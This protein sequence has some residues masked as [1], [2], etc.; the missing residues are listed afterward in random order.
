MKIHFPFS[1]TN[2]EFFH[3]RPSQIDVECDTNTVF[4]PT[5]PHI[6]LADR[7]Q[8]SELDWLCQIDNVYPWTWTLGSSVSMV[9]SFFVG[10]NDNSKKWL[11]RTLKNNQKFVFTITQSQ[12]R[13]RFACA[14]VRVYVIADGVQVDTNKWPSLI[15]GDH[16]MCVEWNK[17]GISSMSL[18]AMPSID[19]GQQR[20]N[21]MR[22]YAARVF[23][24]FSALSF[25]RLL[26][27]NA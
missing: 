15:N 14:C 1:D 17:T 21:Q 3:V 12:K 25:D 10:R 9:W 20:N 11:R 5:S 4:L 19:D 16:K 22:M 8:P 18:C 23:A 27:M 24:L 6:G 13:P 26:R 7:I 2:Y